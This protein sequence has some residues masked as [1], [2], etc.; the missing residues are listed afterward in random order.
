MKVPLICWLAVCLPLSAGTL[1]FDQTKKEVTVDNDQKT[2]TV[3]F[4]FK[5]ESDS[6]ALIER[7]DAGC[8]CATV[9]V[10][11]SKMNYKP[12][13]TGTVRIVFDLGLVPG[14]MDKA[15]AL[16]MKG[17]AANNPSVTLTSHIVVPSLVDVEPK[18]LMWDIGSKPEPKT[19]TV[20]MN[21]SEPI[22]VL[23]ITGA[24]TRFK[25]E[26]KTIEEGKKYEVTITP[27][28]TKQVGMGV[29]HL[30]TDCKYD[31]HRSQRIFMVVR[32]PVAKQAATTP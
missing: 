25:Q 24:D 1:K 28:S 12:G 10:K 23:S 26:L 27:A 19:V 2:V 17:D 4:E 31:R 32:Q 20:T 22:K 7:Y 15:V 9:G 5:N 16:Y 8:P 29:V 30:E 3:D 11:D 14:T 6:E 21:H 18:S 13:E